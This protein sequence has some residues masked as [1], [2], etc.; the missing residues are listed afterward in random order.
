MKVYF[1]TKNAGKVVSV[2]E[3]LAPYD[4][5]VEHVS[6]ELPE[7]RSYDVHQIAREKALY[8]YGKLQKPCLTLDAGFFLSAWN[9]FPRTYVNFALETLGL[10]G[11][12]KLVEGLPRE[13]YF[14]DCIAYCDGS[15]PIVLE[16]LIE[17]SVA[18]H[19]RGEP[20]DYHWS[21]LFQ[22]FVP[23]GLEKTLAEMSREELSQWKKGLNSY[24]GELAEVITQTKS[25]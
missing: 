5:D 21:V 22:I 4:I 7:S 11:L 9:G 19:P 24:Y 20:K 16:R 10:S 12:L 23:N 25:L 1:T 14:K 13:C 6:M 18:D 3:G 8:A 17:G 15:E 2:R